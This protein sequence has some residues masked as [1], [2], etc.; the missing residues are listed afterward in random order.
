M[1]IVTVQS[2]PTNPLVRLESAALAVT[3]TPGKGGDITSIVHRPTEQEVLWQAPWGGRPSGYALPGSGTAE[4]WMQAYPGGWQILV[5]N[6]S[7]ECVHNGVRHGFHGEAALAPWDWSEDG[8]ALTLQLA[9][10]TLPLTMTRR[11]SLDGDLLVIEETLT[12]ESG[13]P[14]ELIWCHHPG[15]GG[16]LLDGPARLTSGARRITVDDQP[17]ARGNALLGGHESDWPHTRGRDGGAVDLRTPLEGQHGMAY[18]HDFADGWAALTRADGAIGIA[19]TWD[20]SLFPTAWLWQELGGSQGGPWF[21]RG[22]VMG[23]EPCTTWPGRG[24]AAAVADDRPLLRLAPGE[25]RETTL[26]LHVFTG[27]GEVAGVQD[28]RA[29]GAATNR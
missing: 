3:V 21:G 27:I 8:D 11:L 16:A 1:P 13:I 23:I 9:F 10:F 26:R 14:V 15:F 6:A 18:L 17:D 4:A 29:H 25:R 22:R 28:G 12:N 5:P 7:N 19:L 2:R 24:L 20:T